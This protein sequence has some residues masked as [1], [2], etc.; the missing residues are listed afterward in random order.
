MTN[1]SAPDPGN[2]PE[3]PSLSVCMI[4]RDEE[5]ILSRCLE[6]VEAVANEL[7][8]VDTGSTDNTVSVAR[9]FG[10]RIFHF[11]WCDDFAA[12]R[13][14]SLKHATGDWILQMDADEKLLSDSVPKL[15]QRMLKSTVL[16][17]LIRC[18]NGS[19]CGQPRFD[20]IGRLFRNH[21]EIR[22]DRP[23]HEG[24]DRAVAKLVSA[25]PRWQ[26][27]R[28]P[29]I[30]I[31]HYGYELSKVSEKN[32]RG[33]PIMESHLRKNPNDAYILNKLGSVYSGLGRYREAEVCLTK[34]L[35]ID[36]DS[37]EINYHLGLTLQRQNKLDSSVEHYEKAINS[38]PMF[39]E[40][41]DNL[42][43]AYIDQGMYEKGIAVLNKAIT[44]DPDLA[45]AHVN[46]GIA[47]S[48]KS[49]FDK[50]IVEYELALAVNPKDAKAHTNLG[51]TYQ[52]KGMLDDAISHH[53]KAIDIDP[54]DSTARVNLG[55]AYHLKGMFDEA[56]A[57]FKQVLRSHPKDGEAHYNLAIAHFEKEDFRE[58]VHHLDKAIALKVEVD[59]KLVKTLQPRRMSLSKK[60]STL[61]D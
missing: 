35:K 27:E 54:S 2:L 30:V 61:R 31:R 52:K 24:V 32:Y 3:N 50:S 33:L 36:P 14:E 6:S 29:C 46:L 1:K 8:V 34:A 59:E 44:L 51:V 58:A 47:Y 55:V 20:W 57:Q 40:A 49:M 10:A 60:E 42:G 4:V 16:C 19:A 15:A 43:L 38:N 22:Y 11:E 23:Y 53:K 26:I 25:N 12:A 48:K 5:D 9:D 13:N 18:D 56:V 37:S 17:F 41:Y 21:P 7:I 28:E 39:A 45:G